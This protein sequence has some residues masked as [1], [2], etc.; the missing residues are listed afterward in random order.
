MEKECVEAAVKFG[1]NFYVATCSHMPKQACGEKPRLIVPAISGADRN[2][3]AAKP[4]GVSAQGGEG[5]VV[6]RLVV[7]REGD[8]WRPGEDSNLR[9]A[10]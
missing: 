3:T 2:T 6:Y 1:I 10:A 8:V 9:P 4:E 5:G 7:Y